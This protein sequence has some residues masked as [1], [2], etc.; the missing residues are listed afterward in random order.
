MPFFIIELQRSDEDMGYFGD[1]PGSFAEEIDNAT[2]FRTYEEAERVLPGIPAGILAEVKPFDPPSDGFVVAARFPTGTVRYLTKSRRGWGT[3]RRPN[4]HS[5]DD[6]DSAQEMADIY[7]KTHREVTTSVEWGGPEQI[8]DWLRKG[9]QV[10]LP[11]GPVWTIA[12]HIRGEVHLNPP[13][14]EG[15][16]VVVWPLKTFLATWDV[17]RSGRFDRFDRLDDD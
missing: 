14:D 4:A 9:T 8:P 2:V 15:D 16:G 3:G 6:R 13:K 11:G 1:G 5:F 17:Y 7:P 12:A 10:N